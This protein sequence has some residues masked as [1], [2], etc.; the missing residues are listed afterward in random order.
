MP[1]WG[2]EDEELWD[3]PTMNRKMHQGTRLDE[4]M[5]SASGQQRAGGGDG[6]VKGKSLHSKKEQKLE[7]T[8]LKADRT[9][10]QGAVFNMS[11][12]LRGRLLTHTWKQLLW[13]PRAEVAMEAF[14]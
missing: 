1:D 4:S 6:R 7:I 10:S 11:W 5:R 13:L 8:G 3:K 14:R 9:H 2:E 12:V